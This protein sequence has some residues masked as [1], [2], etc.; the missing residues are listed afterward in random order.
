MADLAEKNP[1]ALES[2]NQNNKEQMEKL[3]VD[4]SSKRIK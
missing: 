4:A 3:V 2:V 1:E